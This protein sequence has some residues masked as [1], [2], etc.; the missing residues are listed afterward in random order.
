MARESGEKIRVANALNDLGRL[1]FDQEEYEDALSYFEKARP[2]F[3]MDAGFYDAASLYS[4]L[5]FNEGLVYQRLRQFTKAISSFN[6]SIEISAKIG[7]RSLNLVAEEGIGAVMRAEGRYSESLAALNKGE[8]IAI[9]IKDRERLAEIYLLK[10]KTYLA[11]NHLKEASSI[12]QKAAEVA[13]T[14]LSIKLLY[15]IKTTHG[16]IYLAEGKREQAFRVLTEA[17]EGLDALRAEIIGGEYSRFRFWE[18][19]SSPYHLLCNLMAEKKHGLDALFYAER[20]KSRVLYDAVSKRDARTMLSM[21]DNELTEELALS[22]E[23]DRITEEIKVATTSQSTHPPMDLQK[24]LDQAWLKYIVLRNR[25]ISVRSE[26]DKYTARPAIDSLKDLRRLSKYKDTIFLEYVVSEDQVKL[27][28]ITI[29]PVSY[30]PIVK[31]FRLPIKSK[32]LSIK[33]ANFRQHLADRNPL[34]AEASRDL[35]NQLIKPVEAQLVLKKRICI[36]PDVFLWDLPFQALQNAS[37]RYLIEEKPI[38]FAPSLSVLIEMSGQQSPPAKEIS[39]LA[40]AN[41]T[42][43]ESVSKKLSPLPEAE[44]EVKELDRLN[45]GTSK[46]AIGD[47]ATESML[48]SESKNFNVIHLATHGVLNNSNPLLSHL[49]LSADKDKEDGILDAHE[50]MRLNLNADLAVLSACET[51]RGRIGAGE[52]VVGISW[53]FFLAGCRSTVVSQWRVHSESTAHL[54]AKFYRNI[55]TPASKIKA[56]KSQALRIASLEILRDQRYS[57]P[58]YWASFVLVGNDN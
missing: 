28:T 15:A 34:F 36:I 4:V 57:H 46:I 56:P 58:F 2:I 41:P 35:Y 55:G 43:P 13:T 5:C 29:N 33:V 8:E 50:I 14:A 32:D 7:N 18:Q 23:I 39:L 27:F 30:A 6:H 16:E 40:M 1:F 11:M 47:S 19:N 20:A 37:R 44:T 51:A 48:K 12:I 24:K 38:F 49:V 31:I 25:I 10:A 52:G 42:L 45:L 54:M 26:G 21:S 22:R 9:A 3:A 17:V 53:A